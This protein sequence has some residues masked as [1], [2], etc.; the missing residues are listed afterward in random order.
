MRRAFCFVLMF[1]LLLVPSPAYAESGANAKK[2]ANLE[3]I[4]RS[5]VYR[6][7]N[8]DT[9]LYMDSY[10]LVY[11]TKG[12]SYLDK[13]SGGTAQDI[14]VERQS[15]G[16]Y[17]LCPQSE[18]GK[19]Y[20]SYK[21][22]ASVGAT[23]SKSKEIGKN[24]KF[25]IYS[26][27]DS[28]YS[29]SP[30]SAGKKNLT[31]D[32]SEKKSRYKDNYVELDTFTGEK[33]QKW[34]FEKVETEGISLAFVKTKVKLYSVGM[35]YATLVPY[36]FGE[37]DVK[38]ESSDEKVLMIDGEGRYTALATG[39]VKVTA[40][41]DGQKES[42]TIVVTDDP[43]FTWY[44]QHNMS[45][46]D[47]NGEALK[48]IYFTAGGV[49]KK[50]MVDKY[51]SGRDWM[52]G[53]CYLA[54]VAMVLNN[55][56]ARLTEGYDFRSG[57]SNDLPADPYTVALANSGNYGTTTPNAV[58]YG[59]PILVARS[60]IDARFNVDGKKITSTMTY[61]TSKKAIKE[62]LDEH[63]EGIVVYFSMPS[64]GK[65]HYIVFTRCVNP[66]A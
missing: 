26:S 5:G 61:N 65:T 6:I 10:D 52:D 31:L 58:L 25:V 35:L 36:N 60:T 56:G 53:G 12:S 51:G 9:G 30:V 63:P 14:Y 2:N 59:N 62:A 27:G 11:D 57:Q 32:V 48:N 43:A 50:F 1:A 55:M 54:S 29:I 41:V 44:S 4:L 19:Y 47:W 8:A 37:H 28:S 13:K 39:K 49:R 42:C 3:N 40:T 16:T 24:E 64:R 66:D 38:W 33:A 21:N 23:L 20:I 22:G 17:V 18:N 45:G 15:D 46:S 7:K 34:I